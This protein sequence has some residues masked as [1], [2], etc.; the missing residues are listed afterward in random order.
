MVDD[1]FNMQKGNTN[2][3][4]YAFG[5]Y[6][7]DLCHSLDTDP[8]IFY[9]ARRIIPRKRVYAVVFVIGFFFLR[10]SYSLR[11]YWGLMG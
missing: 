4:T 8:K 7:I 2:R 1:R 6:S 11:I 3:R 5:L 10:I 9:D